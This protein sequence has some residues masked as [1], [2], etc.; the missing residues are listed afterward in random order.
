MKDKMFN[1]ILLTLFALFLSPICAEDSS[2]SLNENV[3]A[4]TADDAFTTTDEKSSNQSSSEG[5]AKRKEGGNPF[6]IGIGGSPFVLKDCRYGPFIINTKDSIIGKSLE[7]YGEWDEAG[8]DMALSFIQ[9]GDF[10]IDIGAHIGAHTIPLARATG[11]NGHLVAFEMQRTLAQHL[12]ANLVLNQIYNVEV[13]TS[14]IGENS[15]G[16]ENVPLINY[17]DDGDFAS[18]SLKSHWNTT[19]A[20]FETVNR[21]GL[22]DTFYREGAICPSFLKVDIPGKFGESNRNHSGQCTFTIITFVT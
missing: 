2:T 19:N 17:E 12:A 9:P 6:V 11:P 20:M 18:V 8:V 10:V 13:H 7:Y 3:I 14:A 4:P 22:D 5:G 21:L 15:E 1:L 16:V